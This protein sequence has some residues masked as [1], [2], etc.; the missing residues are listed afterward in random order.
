MRKVLCNRS[1]GVKVDLGWCHAHSEITGQGSYDKLHNPE[2]V[3]EI[4]GLSLQRWLEAPQFRPGLCDIRR[5]VSPL[6]GHFIPRVHAGETVKRI[7]IME[8]SEE[9]PD[10]DALIGQAALTSEERHNRSRRLWSRVDVPLVI[11]VERQ[12]SG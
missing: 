2:G 9:R 1:K 11:G 12:T 6:E 3:G 8:Y 5:P 4:V 7:Q 10:I